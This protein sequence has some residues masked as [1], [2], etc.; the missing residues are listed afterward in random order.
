MYSDEKGPSKTTNVFAHCSAEEEK[1]AKHWW[2]SYLISGRVTLLVA[3]LGYHAV[4]RK[5]R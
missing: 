3:M 2:A 4:A 1:K 5:A